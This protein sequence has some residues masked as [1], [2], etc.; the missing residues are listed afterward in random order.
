MGRRKADGSAENII[1]LFATGNGISVARGRH[2][3]YE[4]GTRVPL[5]FGRRGAFLR[6]Q[7]AMTLWHELTSLPRPCALQAPLFPSIWR[8]AHSSVQTRAL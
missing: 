7:F 5:F 6:K 2:L 1:V 3:L 8:V 4:E